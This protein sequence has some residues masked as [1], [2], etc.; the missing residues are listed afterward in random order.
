MK[1]TPVLIAS[2]FSTDLLSGITAAPIQKRRKYPKDRKTDEKIVYAD[3]VTAF[4]IETSIFEVE[5]DGPQGFMYI[6][7]WQIG[8]IATVYGRTWDEFL[9]LVTRL[10]TWLESNNWRLLVY[11]HNLSYEFQYL[12]GIWKFGEDDVFATD[13]RRPLYC[14]MGR[15]EFR[16]SYRLSGESLKGWAKHMGVDHQKLDDF[17]YTAVRYPWSPLTDEEYQYCWND[18][19]S[20]V[21]CVET[22]L[23]MYGDT[24]YS[25]PLTKTGYVRRMVRDNMRMWSPGGIR[26]MQ[27]D[28]RTYDRLRQAFRGGDTHANRYWVEAI[29]GDV[30]S[31]D[32]SSSY[33]DV[34]VHCK[35]PMSIFREEEASIERFRQLCE[36]GSRACL[37][38]LCFYN[39]RL[40][41]GE[42]GNPYLSFDKC[43]QSGFKRPIGEELDNGRI[44]NASYCEMAMTE[45]DYRIIEEQY[46]WDHCQVLWLMSA[47]YG[48][49]PQPLVDV[50]LNLYKKKTALKGV[51]GE[52]VRYALDKAD[53]NSI[54]G[55]MCQQV[56]SL[57]IVFREGTWIPD[58]DGFNRDEE[59]QKAIE[60]AKLNYAWA[61]WVTAWARWRLYEGVYIATKENPLNFVYC[62]TDSIKSRDP[63]NLERY[64]QARIRD[65]KASGAFAVDAKGETHYMG[66]FEPEGK[67]EQFV[68]LGAKRYCYLLDGQLSITVAG[69]PK[70]AGAEELKR[71]G[72]I[73]AF[74]DGFLFEESG[75]L[76][77]VYNDYP[78]FWVDTP[79][80]IPLHITRNVYL[81]PTTYDL[82]LESNYS[83]MLATLQDTLDS[84]TQ[85]D[86][87]VKRSAAQLPLT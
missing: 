10:N 73:E 13:V 39:I 26:N 61:V 72:G 62:D 45:I 58:R 71:K 27:N 75:K 38:K 76:M 37:V 18:V 47:R 67:Y 11:V 32:R 34:I 6:W 60:N 29:L 65:A 2:E 49:L 19:L 31:Y 35:F 1:D 53:L 59:Y 33:P 80:G 17:Q 30:L 24:L 22:M 9:D 48:L 43:C 42:T 20:V 54:Y 50:V 63:I 68:T 41:R 44:L 82:S 46:T 87:Y 81:A 25:I 55:M 4:D 64:N 86:Y 23:H 16:C 36:D 28:L 85:T 7:Q 3:M 69:V 79:D 74:L 15:L 8:H 83:M 84:W 51:V 52:E 12:A 14:K 5:E 77:A 57:P 78:D 70:K 66:V 56:I 21:E 40:I